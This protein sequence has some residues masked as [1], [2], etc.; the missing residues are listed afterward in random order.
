M[1]FNNTSQNGTSIHENWVP[2]ALQF[3]FGLVGNILALVLLK[4][5]SSQH[6]WRSFY[7]LY[8][9]LVISDLSIWLLTTPL[10][11]A[12]YATHFT[13]SF[14]PIIC[15]YD[16]FMLMFALTSSAFIIGAMTV[17]RFLAMARPNESATSSSCVYVVILLGIWVLAGLLSA[18]HLTMHLTK[19][20]YPGSWC[21]MDYVNLTESK[22]GTLHAYFYSIV[23]LSVVFIIA[24]INLLMLFTVVFNKTLRARLMD[25]NRI[26][27]GYDAHSYVF[28]ATV[29]LVFSSLWTP[30][31]VSFFFI[32]FLPL[33][34]RYTDQKGV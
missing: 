22:S 20:F 12:R 3:V 25:T 6:R 14:P 9:G 8:T 10:S 7:Q 21:Y 32:S 5:S 15:R 26:S 29:A 19:N 30:H 24:T 16:S 4:L 1:A 34:P 23:G 33:F 11:I 28:L 17:D 27:G 13:W 18:V 2:M 31:L